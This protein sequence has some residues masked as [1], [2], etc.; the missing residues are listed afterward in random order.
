MMYWMDWHLVLSLCLLDLRHLDE[1]EMLLIVA[2]NNMTQVNVYLRNPPSGMY[3]VLHQE[4]E[5]QR[6]LFE[7]VFYQIQIELVS[8]GEYVSRYYDLI[9]LETIEAI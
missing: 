5:T 9:S 2:M 4:F 8:Q 1:F 6:S 7:I 3:L